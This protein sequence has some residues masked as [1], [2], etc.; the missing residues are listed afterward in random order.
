M[1]DTNEY[2]FFSLT[3]SLGCIQFDELTSDCVDINYNIWSPKYHYWILLYRVFILECPWKHSILW[4]TK[5]P[6][7]SI[8]IEMIWFACS[9]FVM[10]LHWAFHVQRICTIKK[11]KQLSERKNKQFFLLLSCVMTSSPLNALHIRCIDA[12]LVEPAIVFS[13]N[14]SFFFRCLSALLWYAACVCV[15]L[16]VS[17][18]HFDGAAVAVCH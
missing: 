7:Y 11:N 2:F 16:Y 12:N 3:I 14:L 9:N 18:F 17:L 8:K 5:T 4:Q 1:H 6:E 13:F 15:C 10:H